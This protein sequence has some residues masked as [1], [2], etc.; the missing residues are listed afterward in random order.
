MI[1]TSIAIA[2]ACTIHTYSTYTDGGKQGTLQPM[3]NEKRQTCPERCG[4]FG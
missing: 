1:S 4:R 2:Y 3:I